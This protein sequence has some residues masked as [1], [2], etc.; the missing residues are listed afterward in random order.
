MSSIR[1][2]PVALDTNQYVLGIRRSSATCAEILFD[3]VPSLRIFVPLRIVMEIN[4]NL[5]EYEQQAVYDV[6]GSAAEVLWDYAEPPDEIVSQYKALG[7]KKGDAV[8]A[9]HLDAAGVRWLISE[10]RHFLSEIDDLPFTVL[11]SKQALDEF[12]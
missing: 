7:A 3:R 6:L 12:D 4:R 2:D 9:A 5:L 8:I 1:T 10:N 11:T